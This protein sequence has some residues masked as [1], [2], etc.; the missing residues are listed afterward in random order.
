M[1]EQLDIKPFL[2]SIT[3]TPIHGGIHGPSTSH[4]TLLPP[5]TQAQA[6]CVLNQA[7]SELSSGTGYQTSSADEALEGTS[8]HRP[9]PA[10]RL[11]RKFWGAGDYD[12]GAGSSAQRSQ[13]T[14]DGT[15]LKCFVQN[16]LVLG[17][18]PLT[19]FL[20]KMCL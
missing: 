7:A 12:V 8:A 16:L 5:Q 2:S 1:D 9:C 18:V 20:D 14:Y 11:S 17:S 3:T 10:P 13:S 6:A 19:L 15:M 4:A